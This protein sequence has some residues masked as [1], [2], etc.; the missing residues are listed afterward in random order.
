MKLESIDRQFFVSVV[1]NPENAKNRDT[2]NSL[3]VSR[4]QKRGLKNKV[5]VYLSPASWSRSRHLL[6]VKMSPPLCCRVLMV[7]KNWIPACAG[8]GSDKSVRSIRTVTLACVRVLQRDLEAIGENLIK[9]IY[10]EHVVRGEGVDDHRR[11]ADGDGPR[12]SHGA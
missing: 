5:Q 2:H 6:R 8:M 12:G 10:L 3:P 1:P 7:T 11:I 9:G 4:L